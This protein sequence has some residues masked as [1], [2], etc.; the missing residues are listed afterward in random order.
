MGSS[1]GSHPEGKVS[2]GVQMGGSGVSWNGNLPIGSSWLVP[3]LSPE[4]DEFLGIQLRET[5]QSSQKGNLLV[6]MQLGVSHGLSVG[7][8][9]RGLRCHPKREILSLERSLGVPCPTPK[10]KL[11]C[12]EQLEGARTVP[13]VRLIYGCAT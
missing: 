3:E 9:L 4:G 2:H 1:L 6:G 8:Q 13:T 10:G 11:I 12:G 7:V 5:Q